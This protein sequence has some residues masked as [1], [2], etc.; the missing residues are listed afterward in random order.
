MK[1]PAILVVGSFVMDQIATTEVFPNEGQ[2]VLGKSFAKAP[3]GKGANQAVQASRLGADVTMTG[4][5]G[6]DANGEEMIRVC[7]EA[8]INTAH[9][10]YD[11]NEA[12]GCAVIILESRPGEQT[13]N[14][15]VVLPGSNMT[16]TQDDIAFLKDEISQY[17]M[18]ILQLEIPMEINETVAALAHEAGVP[19]MLNP[20]PSAPISDTLISNL[21]YISP[22]EHEIAD[23]TGIR[24]EHEGKDINMD[25]VKAACQALKDKGAK[26]VL[27]TL[28]ES[29]AALLSDEGFYHAPCAQGVMAVDPTAAGDSFLGAF[30]TGVCCGWD[31]EDILRFANHTSAITVSNLGAMPS[32]PELEAV[33]AYMMEKGMEIPDTSILK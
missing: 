23:I 9:V 13:K 4:K 3:G 15:I 18:V 28:G 5:L 12:S 8:G 33:E 31:M 11:D 24:I 7:D 6:R 25:Q 1:K 26:N 17:D 2:T 16:M 21:T 29:G 22:N 30:C 32:L 10:A 14:R 27:V 20:A 19:V